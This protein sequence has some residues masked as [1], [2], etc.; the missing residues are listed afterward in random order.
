M[1]NSKLK[2]YLVEMVYVDFHLGLLDPT[3]LSGGCARHN[4]YPYVTTHTLPFKLV[5]AAIAALTEQHRSG[6][7]SRA[8]DL[9][10]RLSRPCRSAEI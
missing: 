6:V 9:C 8:N 2:H 7:G 3:D 10:M 4:A 1:P 5:K